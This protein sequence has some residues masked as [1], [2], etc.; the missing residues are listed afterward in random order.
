M[1]CPGQS[2][3]RRLFRVVSTMS[4]CSKEGC[5][6]GLAQYTDVLEKAASCRLL[7]TRMPWSVLEL[8]MEPS[9][10]NQGKLRTA[11]FLLGD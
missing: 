5:L 1:T 7:S 10:N 8:D 9:F 2:C 11:L 4:K 6:V 3:S